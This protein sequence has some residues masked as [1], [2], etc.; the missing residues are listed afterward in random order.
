M[1]NLARFCGRERGWD[2]TLFNTEDPEDHKVAV[3]K[4]TVPDRRRGD[5]CLELFG[6]ACFRFRMADE[7]LPAHWAMQ[8]VWFHPYFRDHGKLKEAWPTLLN[9]FGDFFPEPPYSPAMSGF[10]RKHA[11]AGQRAL[12]HHLEE[13]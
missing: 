9:D 2:Y 13:Q 12:F 10:L 4:R 11:S 6:A 3:F 8:W 5:D 7:P 1:F